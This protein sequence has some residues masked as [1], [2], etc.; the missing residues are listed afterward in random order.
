M[1]ST[2]RNGSKTIE[3]SDIFTNFEFRFV[4]SSMKYRINVRRKRESQLFAHTRVDST[5]FL[6]HDK[7][8]NNNEEF[9]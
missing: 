3:R 6:F 2:T 7:E 4:F 8:R 9:V 5:T 1:E